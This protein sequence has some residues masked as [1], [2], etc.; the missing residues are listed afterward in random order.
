MQLEVVRE[1]AAGLADAT[2]GV[3]V[4]LDALPRDPTDS[5]PAVPFILDGTSDE[6]VI[7][8][9]QFARGHDILILVT[10]DG[11][12]SF[13]SVNKSSGG[14]ALGST[15]VSIT[16]SHRGARNPIQKLQ[17][18]EYVG[19]AVMLAI[20]AYFGRPEVRRIR[21]EVTIMQLTGFRFGLI[22][23]DGT[24][25]IGALVFTVQSFDK[26]AQALV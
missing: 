25:S 16:I 8:G 17:D 6:E 9:E 26:R 3:V 24:G 13:S 22:Q 5:P 23:D 10:P 20:G 12:T 21:N 15:P 18:A 11:P 1:I 19:R 7:K 4:Q 2:T 14:F